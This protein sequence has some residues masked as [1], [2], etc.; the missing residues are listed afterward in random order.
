M[1]QV[2][3]LDFEAALIELE[4]VVG[5]LDGEVKLE[6]ALELFDKGMRLSVDC[7]SFLKTAEQKIE[8]LRRTANGEVIAESFETT[9]SSGEKAE[10]QV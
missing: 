3:P 6:R 7:E 5:E 2:K 8:I 10:S 1:T 9:A 4:K